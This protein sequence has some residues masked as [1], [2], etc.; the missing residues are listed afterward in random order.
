MDISKIAYMLQGEAILSVG[1]EYPRQQDSKCKA[2]EVSLVDVRAAADIRIHY[3]FDRNG[4]VITME[5]TERLP[6]GTNTSTGE[7]I[8]VGFVEAYQ[9]Q[10]N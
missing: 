8:E 1:I 9:T 3:D 6:S 2:V 4:W 5:K 10:V 7:W